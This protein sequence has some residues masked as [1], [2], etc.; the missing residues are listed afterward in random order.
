MVLGMTHLEKLKAVAL[1]ATQGPWKYGANPNCGDQPDDILHSPD[2]GWLSLTESLRKSDAQF[3]AAANPA[4]VLALISI[5]EAQDRALEFYA[6]GKHIMRESE[7]GKGNVCPPIGHHAREARA[8]VAA[9]LSSLQ[10]EEMG[11]GAG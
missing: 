8:S 10:G 5:I 11:G 1:A 7:A 4:T 6:A 9:K 2:W 3:I